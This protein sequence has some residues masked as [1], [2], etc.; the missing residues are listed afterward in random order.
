M[1]SGFPDHRQTMLIPD[2]A[3]VVGWLASHFFRGISTAD[4]TGISPE[5]K[6]LRLPHRNDAEISK[7]C[8]LWTFWLV[9]Q[10]INDLYKIRQK[11][12][13]QILKRLAESQAKMF[14]GCRFLLFW[15]HSYEVTLSYSKEKTQDF[16][17]HIK[18][19]FLDTGQPTIIPLT[20]LYPGIESHSQNICQKSVQNLCKENAGI[21]V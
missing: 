4:I 19:P 5:L 12:L 9:I 14:R 11:T 16:L 1:P 2:T 7:I 21:N 15:H 13:C 18:S 6:R 3:F 8:H 17:C 20:C 10:L